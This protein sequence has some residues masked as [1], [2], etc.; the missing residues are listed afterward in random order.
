VSKPP[1]A[2]RPPTERD[3]AADPRT[4]SNVLETVSLFSALSGRHLKKVAAAAR[5]ARFHDGTAIV[6]A[7][8]P[9]DTLFVVLDGD[10]IV[11][12]RGAPELRLGMGSFFGEMALLDGGARSATVLA[13]GPVVCLAI[14]RQRFVKVLRS[15][16]SIAV[17]MLGELA[18]RLRTA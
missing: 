2:V 9:R 15:E 17:A 10:V 5:I 13:D 18:A 6:R 11:R 4:W 12:R 1:V 3:L 14:S 8:E 7:G 16:P